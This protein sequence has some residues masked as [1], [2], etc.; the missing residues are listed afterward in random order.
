VAFFM[1]QCGARPVTTR[2]IEDI[3][4]RPM[5]SE[6][7]VRLSDSHGADP[8]EWPADLRVQM[9]PGEAWR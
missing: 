6:T 5:T 3:H 1:K 4:G 8:S 7:T 9:F 2:R